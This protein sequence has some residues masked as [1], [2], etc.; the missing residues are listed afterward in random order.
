M[1]LRIIIKNRLAEANDML[2]LSKSKCVA[3]PLI[4]T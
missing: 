1:N 2:K 3:V 4:H